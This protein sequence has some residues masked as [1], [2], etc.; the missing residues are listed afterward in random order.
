MVCEIY[1]KEVSQKG[2]IKKTFQRSMSPFIY[3]LRETG[4]QRV[5]RSNIRQYQINVT[6]VKVTVEVV[7][8]LRAFH[9]LKC[10]MSHQGAGVQECDRLHYLPSIPGYGTFSTGAAAR[11]T[12]FC[13]AHF[14]K[15][16]AQQSFIHQAL[17]DHLQSP[18]TQSPLGYRDGPIFSLPSQSSL[19]GRKKGDMLIQIE[20]HI[21]R[22]TLPKL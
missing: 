16:F 9:V 12:R 22:S 13:R 15:Q 10:T 17:L 20:Q 1:S 6:Q 11:R 2:G 8:I 14:R 4:Y 21:G 5:P 7:G 19:S 18:G 3:T